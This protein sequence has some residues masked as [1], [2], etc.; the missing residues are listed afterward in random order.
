M[1]AEQLA[2]VRAGFA[3]ID[4][5]PA[6]KDRAL[7]YLETWLSASE[8]ASYRPQVDWL[9]AQKQWT[10]IL[11]RFYQIL[12]FGTGGRRGSVGI[13]PNRMN[14]WTL[15]ASVQGHCQY[16]KERFPG[17]P[18]LSVVVAYDVRRFE[19][20]RKQYCPDLPNPLLGLSSKKL[21]H[22]AGQVYAAN[23]IQCWLPAPDTH[24]FL[25]TPELSHAIR[26][27][28]A[29]GGLNISASHNPPD[30][31]G[32]KFYDEHGGQPIAPDDQ[33]MADLVDQVT[34]IHSLDW[35]D[36]VK[37][38]LICFMDDTLHQGYLDLICRQSLLGPVKQNECT[39]VFTPL[40]GVGRFT[41]TEVLERQKFRVVPVPSQNEP[42][43]LFPNV[44][45]PN[46]EVPASM[47]EARAL[48]EQINADA[49]LSTDPD[50]DRVGMMIPG[51]KG[52]RIVNGNEI[53]AL[54]T[55]FKLE[56]LAAA[57]TLPH[58]PIVMKTE[59]TTNLITR[60]ARRY[61]AQ[62]IDDLLVGF[63]YMA[64][65]LNQI[66][67]NGSYGEVRGRLD[68][69]VIATEESHGM[70]V[71]PHL[72]DKDAAGAALLLAEWVAV[73]KRKGH[74]AYGYVQNMYRTFGYFHNRVQ[75]IVLPGIL[76][77]KLMNDM[78]NS[79]RHDPPKSIGG[80]SVLA[81]EDRQ[82]ENGRWGPLKGATDAAS[83]NVLVF[84][85]ERQA[86]LVLRPS[87]TEPKAKAYIETCGD[88]CPAQRAD[89][90]WERQCADIDALG[91]QLGKA[92]LELALGRVGLK[93]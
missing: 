22:L 25:A 75:N 77:K 65:A 41:V 13:G 72:R 33:I 66:E 59:V 80:L 58:A 63:K 32:G 36:A 45:S 61:G 55:L 92:F 20:T 39:I 54:G 70:I 86:Q 88:P 60:I 27:L 42:D 30:D 43:G 93:P 67:A 35:N 14:P 37:R 56:Y 91:E 74:T 53:A 85:L 29:H 21:A 18:R 1:I 8:F 69:F 5:D 73:Q 46:P 81:A 90:E 6:A 9:I 34:T 10:G 79:L 11:D 48:A 82:D 31:N 12:P 84:K 83:R 87:G 24:R 89:A 57:G 26:K 15:T 71:T 19:D 40:Q 64:D 47:D 38:Q 2:A 44:Q 16:L 51:P 76:G 23:G 68:D 4:V 50:A 7:R 17:T 78:L 62:V 3:G 52:W 28:N 49:V